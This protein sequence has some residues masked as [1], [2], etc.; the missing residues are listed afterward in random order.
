MRRQARFPVTL[1][2]KIP[3]T[4]RTS[5][6]VVCVCSKYGD[7][8]LA[9]L[10]GTF[11]VIMGITTSRLDLGKVKI[12]V[13][14]PGKVTEIK[15]HNLLFIFKTNVLTISSSYFWEERGIYLTLK[16]LKSSLI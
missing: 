13:S 14:L 12:R 6:P 5:S 4:K 8:P 10:L 2:Q 15:N 1:F 16:F 3:S 9:N 11:C 7:F